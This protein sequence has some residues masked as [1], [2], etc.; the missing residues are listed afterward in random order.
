MCLKA[1]FTSV[2]LLVHNRSVNCRIMFC[3]PVILWSLNVVTETI[4][5]TEGRMLASPVLQVSN[6]TRRKCA[7]SHRPTL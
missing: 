7:F 3:R 5:V 6:T 1:Y 4:Q 2:H